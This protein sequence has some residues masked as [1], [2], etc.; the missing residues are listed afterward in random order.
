MKLLFDTIIIIN[1]DRCKDRYDRIISRIQNLG[2]DK[3]VKIIRISAV[4]GTSIDED[5]LLK[6]KVTPLPDYYDTYRGRGLTMGEIG[7]AVSHYKAWEIISKDPS[8][9]SALIL[10]DDAQFSPDF[11]EQI[12]R[13][14]NKAQ[15]LPWELFYL[16]RKKVSSKEEE[17]IVD[18]IVVPEFSYWC[19][20]YVVSKLGSVKLTQSK[21]LEA[22]IPADEF[23]PIMIDKSN[24]TCLQYK[25]NYNLDYLKPFALTQQL[26]KPE[27]SAFQ[28]SNT[29]KT[30]VFF[31]NDFYEDG[32]DKFILLTVATEENDHLDRFRKSCEYY[33]VPY[34]I[35]GLGNKWNGGEA[36]NGVLKTFGGGQK[37]NLL[38]EELKSWEKL[39]DHIVLFTDSYDVVLL[40]NPQSI[41][42]KF[43]Q[44]RSP[45]VFSAEKTCWPDQGLVLEYP[46]SET[47]YRF[48]NSGGFIGYADE[49]FKLIE[50]GVDDRD[51][52]QLFYT[53]AYLKGIKNSKVV[54]PIKSSDNIPKSEYPKSENGHQI[55][56]MSEPV[57]DSQIVEWLTRKFN[58]KSKILDIGAGDGKWGYVLRNHFDHID[59]V[60][61]F[62]PYIKR[63]NLKNLYKNIFNQNFLEF[64]FEFYDAIIMGD[65]FEH[66]TKREAQ[67]WLKKIKDK[68]S[69]IVIVVPYGYKQDWDGEYENKWGHHHQPKLG[70]HTM[71][72]DFPELQLRA[73]TD[74]PDSAGKG[75]GFG[76]Y[77]KKFNFDF[78]SNIFLDSYQYIFQT[79]NQA[80]EDINVDMVG[81]ISNVKTDNFPSVLHANG[82]D[83]IKKY[84][85]SITDY[86]IGNFDFFYGNKVPIDKETIDKTV[87]IGLFFEHKIPDINQPLD[88]LS[89]LSYP[90]EK[91]DLQIYYNDDQHIY[92][93]DKFIKKNPQYNNITIQ[94]SESHTGS[95]ID[96]LKK[97]KSD[98]SLML[99]SNYIFRNVNSIQILIS[100]DKKILSP[101]IVS[102]LGGYVNFHIKDTDMKKEYSSYAR[103]GVWSVDVVSG[104]ILV[105]EDFLNTV[106]ESLSVP[107]SHPDG[108]W[109]VSLCENLK[110]KGNFSYICNTNYFGTII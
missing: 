11:M 32:T 35:L 12:M 56:W 55:G 44:F 42:Y 5:W 23:V 84:L 96:F 59:A 64:E 105:R 53:K 100:A 58:K 72:K 10:E 3:F 22:L 79:L 66:V 110:L 34:K 1:L 52:D 26:I 21:F 62:E 37:I 16:G 39:N 71:T 54:L 86:T 30:S 104:I 7:C 102:E 43:R 15:N 87:S 38:K 90:K 33:G 19:L 89:I 20:S 46:Y 81:R 31:K 60:E 95:R 27:T 70:V 36:E 97:S 77:T 48:L 91:I 8:V 67:E 9:N 73:W 29:E 24:S 68:C 85:D 94:K 63:Y 74:K 83:K 6:N 106:I 18:D 4:D 57:F 40:Q 108:D 65:V 49:I 41:L 50:K 47:E 28:N 93:L 51:D 61:I 109:D 80:I 103:K 88:Q 98:F 69:D 78:K 13:I 76:F 14:S 101:M 45:I 75:K 99:D 25:D 107:T 92:K 17:V 82:P 2:L